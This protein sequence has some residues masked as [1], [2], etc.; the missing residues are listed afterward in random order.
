[1]ESIDI[2]MALTGVAYCWASGEIVVT[3]EDEMF[4]QPE[5]TIIFARGALSALEER[6]SARARQ[7]YE[8]GVLLVPGLPELERVEDDDDFDAVARLMLWLDWAFPDWPAI[9]G[10]HTQPDLSVE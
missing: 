10:V 7:G 6:I 8:P 9:D 3:I 4:E 5:G 2:G 1:M